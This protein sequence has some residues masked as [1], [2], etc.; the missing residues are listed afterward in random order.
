MK[1]FMTKRSPFARKVLITAIEKNLLDEIECIVVDMNDKPGELFEINPFGKIPALVGRDARHYYESPIIC[2]YLD[3][4]SAPYLYPQV[5]SDRLRVL[6]LAALADGIIAISV[7]Y[8]KETFRPQELQSE[9]LKKKYIASISQSL[10]YINVQVSKFGTDANPAS[11]A[12]ITALG[13]LEFRLPKI[14]WKKR[15]IA[16][17]DWYY[18]FSERPS[19]QRTIPIL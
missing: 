9:I 14:D 2:E 18:A 12:L 13:Y 5:L 19:V 15:N 11:I 6:N 16:L 7:D 3:S 17:K 1:L 4:L 8:V 10:D